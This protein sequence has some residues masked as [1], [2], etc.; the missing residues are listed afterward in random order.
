MATCGTSYISTNPAPALFGFRNPDQKKSKSLAPKPPRQRGDGRRP[1]QSHGSLKRQSLERLV[2][3]F[4]KVGPMCE[5][6][7]E[8]LMGRPAE[9][10]RAQW[11]LVH[12]VTGG[13]MCRQPQ[14]KSGSKQPR[15]NQHQHHAEAQEPQ[16]GQILRLSWS[17]S[18]SAANLEHGHLIWL[19]LFTERTP[20]LTNLRFNLQEEIIHNGMGKPADAKLTVNQVYVSNWARW[21]FSFKDYS[22]KFVAFGET[23]GRSQL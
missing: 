9:A 7:S 18:T 16:S 23:W 15:S 14:Q 13:F 5:I 11:G 12:Y 10:G 21:R 17:V 1:F 19:W 4:S 2:C 3:P 6:E 22:L 8:V 20:A